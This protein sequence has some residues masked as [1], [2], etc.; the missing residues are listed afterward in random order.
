MAIQ[1]CTYHMAGHMSLKGAAD[2]VDNY[3]CQMENMDTQQLSGMDTSF[4][5]LQAR[6][7]GGIVKQLVGMDKAVT[8][9]FSKDRTNKVTVE[10]GEA[11]WGDKAAVI[12]ISMFVLWPLTV[13]SG[14]GLYQQSRLPHKIKSVLDGYFCE[15]SVLE[16][17]SGP[18]TNIKISDAVNGAVNSSAGQ[19]IIAH[20]DKIVDAIS[21]MIR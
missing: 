17:L 16:K 10:I 7:K 4:I 19:K 13:T 20:A 5:I 21:K 3:L 8:V 12:T 15:N 11:K 6:A 9:R 18:E 2:A 1:R 14:I